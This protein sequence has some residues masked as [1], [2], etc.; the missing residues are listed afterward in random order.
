MWTFSLKSEGAGGRVKSR[1]REK[2]IKSPGREEAQ[3]VY[4]MREGLCDDSPRALGHER[5]KASE[6]R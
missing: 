5:M 1:N 3:C 2:C 6:I 4:G